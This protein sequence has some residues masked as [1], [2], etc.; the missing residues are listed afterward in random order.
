M[1]TVKPDDVL[2]LGLVGWVEATEQSM[3]YPNGAFSSW[4]KTSTRL[5][6]FSLVATSLPL[7]YGR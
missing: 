1:R 7:L 6:L 5:V 2:A 3:W 4:M